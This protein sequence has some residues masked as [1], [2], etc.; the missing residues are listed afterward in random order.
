MKWINEHGVIK[1]SAIKV[2]VMYWCLLVVCGEPFV[3]MY[4]NNM[5]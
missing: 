3:R 4:E 2:F 1:I 5:F